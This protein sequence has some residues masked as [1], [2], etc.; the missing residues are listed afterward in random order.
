MQINENEMGRLKHETP[1]GV[2]VGVWGVFLTQ[3]SRETLGCKHGIPFL[4]AGKAGGIPLHKNHWIILK[5]KR[6]Y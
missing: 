4:P 5:F 2:W 6:A 3:G 1:D